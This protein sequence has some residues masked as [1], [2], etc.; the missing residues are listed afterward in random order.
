MHVPIAVTSLE[1]KDDAVSVEQQI[2][3]TVTA[4]VEKFGI[5]LRQAVAEQQFDEAMEK[6][7]TLNP[8]FHLE[9]LKYFKNEPKYII[10]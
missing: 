1:P 6:I 2:E 9:L 8:A 4:A 10:F 3:R 5:E 7:K